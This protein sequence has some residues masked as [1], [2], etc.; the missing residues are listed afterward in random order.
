[1]T[2]RPPPA[3][4][5]RPVYRRRQTPVDQFFAGAESVQL[6]NRRLADYEPL[7]EALAA[8]NTVDVTHLL[9]H[10]TV[11]RFPVTTGELAEYDALIV[12]DL[13]QD[14]LLPHFRLEEIPG[15][16]RVR[17][18][19]DYVRDGGGLVYCGG[20]MSFQGYHG[21]GN[22][23][24]SPVA[25]LLPV[26]V[27]NVFDDRVERPEGVQVE[28]VDCDNP[29][30]AGL[31]WDIVPELYGYNRVGDV[32]ENARELASVA[33]DPLIAVGEAD[34]GRV[35][36]YMSDPG[37]KWGLAFTDWPEYGAFW[38]GVLQWVCDDGLR[39]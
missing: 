8:W 30:T 39:R 19:A 26:S 29:V 7:L 24:D 4:Y 38:T 36:A 34:A 5:G 20:W 22:W 25:E 2:D 37:P 3:G 1:L 6:F 10:E 16:N 13:S 33:G 14:T 32:A 15:P 28:E 21:I 35:V 11:D 18:I 27:A 17:I 9:A 23:A 12:S 31:D